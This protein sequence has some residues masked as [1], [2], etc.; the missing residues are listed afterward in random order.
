MRLE[1]LDSLLLG[2][3][4]RK[5]LFLILHVSTNRPAMLHVIVHDD[6]DGHVLL[7]ELR[8]RL[9]TARRVVVVVVFRDSETDGL[10]HTLELVGVLDARW[11]RSDSRVPEGVGGEGVASAPAET[12]ESK[13]RL[14]V[15]LAQGADESREAR[16]L[17]GG[18]VD[19]EG[20]EEEERKRLRQGALEERGLR[21]H[22]VP[23]G[24]RPGRE[25]ATCSQRKTQ[26]LD[27]GMWR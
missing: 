14:R 21:V 13:L 19:H 22:G 16:D 8:L 3:I 5:L 15:V 18:I 12:N 23:R 6:L 24:Q 7:L 4:A 9:C 26:T 27:D 11:V 20:D 1:P 2:I 10:R 25:L 17:L